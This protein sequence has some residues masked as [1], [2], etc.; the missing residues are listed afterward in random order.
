MLVALIISSV[1]LFRNLNQTYIMPL[2][3]LIYPD[4]YSKVTLGTAS[5]LQVSRCGRSRCGASTKPGVDR[6]VLVDKSGYPVG[7]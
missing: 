7:S 2:C 1:L 3:H 6:K 4:S 5:H